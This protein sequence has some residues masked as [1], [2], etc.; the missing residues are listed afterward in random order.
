MAFTTDLASP[1]SVV[2]VSEFGPLAQEDKKIGKTTPNK[3][4]YGRGGIITDS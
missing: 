1:L 4:R 2:K 3:S